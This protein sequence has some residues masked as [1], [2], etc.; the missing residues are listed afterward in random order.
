MSQLLR[1]GD[2]KDYTPLGQDGRAVYTIAG[3]IRDAIRLKSSR[4]HADYLAIPQRNDTGNSIDWYIPFASDRPDQ[5]YFIIPWTSATDEE[6]VESLIALDQFKDEMLTLGKKLAKIPNLAGDQLL[7]SRLLYA[8]NLSAEE[9][10]KAIRFPNEEHVYLVNGRPVITFWGFT[11]KRQAQMADPFLCL[12]PLEP[13]VPQVVTPPPPVVEPI[14]EN[15]VVEQPRRKCFLFNIEHNCRFGWCHWC[16]C[17]PLLALL[18]GFLVWWFNPALFP[19]G[20]LNIAGQVPVAET[21]KV[22]TEKTEPRVHYM[23]NGVVRDKN[24][25]VVDDP[26][27][28]DVILG[29]DKFPYYQ[30]DGQW[31][32]KDNNLPVDGSVRDNLAA[33]PTNTTPATEAKDGVAPTDPA[34]NTEDKGAVS[35]VDPNLNTGQTPEPDQ[36]QQANDGNNNDGNNNGAT[37]PA[38]DLNNASEAKPDN[39]A[40]Q[41]DGVNNTNATDGSAKNPP[42]SLDPNAMA[43]GNTKFLNGNWTAGAGIQDKATGKPLKLRYEFKDGKGSVTLQRG[44]GVSC[45][46]NVAASVKSGGLNIDNGGVANCSDGSTYQLPSVVCRP[47]AKNIADCNGSYG[48]QQFPMTMKSQQQ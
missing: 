11:D 23:V 46:A 43:Q 16:L 42:L 14:V 31:L 40:S 32:S 6:R 7:F 47:G 30:K 39:A 25:R 3:Q 21:E 33:M 45:S 22:E 26:K 41:N 48:N 1:T 35:P 19:F 27:S 12:R 9:Q 37:P 44:D 10:L 17:L 15:T 38:P 8:E 18:L 28:C 2:L 4:T 34:N 24:G 13:E 20:G 5:S 29:E 36:G